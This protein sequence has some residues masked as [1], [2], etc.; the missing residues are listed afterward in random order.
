MTALVRMPDQAEALVLR[1]PSTHAPRWFHNV[2]AF[3]ADAPDFN[4]RLRASRHFAT[5]LARLKDAGI[6]G[7]T[8][9]GAIC[10]TSTSAAC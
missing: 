4:R 10:A 2:G 7:P 5:G 3:A 9:P 6:L 1:G 8:P